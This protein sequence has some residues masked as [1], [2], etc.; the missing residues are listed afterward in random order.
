MLS[1]K[2]E[3]MVVL[4]GK[5]PLYNSHH[6]DLFRQ[7]SSV[8][9]N[10]GEAGW[11]IDKEQ[12]KDIFQSVSTK[13]DYSLQRK[14]INYTIEK[15][16]NTLTKGPKLTLSI[17]HRLSLCASSCDTLRKWGQNITYYSCCRCR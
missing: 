13:R 8:N 9:G 16:D 5:S 10:S 17:Y 1:N 14:T 11:E 7:E 12:D 3:G 6:N 2:C 15:P 4:G